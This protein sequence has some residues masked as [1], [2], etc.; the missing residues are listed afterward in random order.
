MVGGGFTERS[1]SEVTGDAK[2][3]GSDKHIVSD[4]RIT[5]APMTPPTENPYP[6][7]PLKGDWLRDAR[8]Y[9]AFNR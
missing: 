5:E 6:E 9:L 1:L 8:G 2:N 7:A 3:R 4:G